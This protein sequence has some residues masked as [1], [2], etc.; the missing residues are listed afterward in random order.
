MAGVPAVAAPDPAVLTEVPC[1]LCGSSRAE[2]RF[3]DPPYRV[4]RCSD[5]T[6]IYVT[7]RREEAK[8]RAMYEVDYWRSPSAKE[9]GYTD[10]LRDEPLYRRTYRRRFAA[11]RRHHPKPGRVLD[12][13]CAAGFFLSIAKEEGW[14]CTGVEVSPAMAAFARERYGLDVRLG[15][16][17]EQ[18][19]SPA[20]FDLV[21]FWDVIEHLPDPAAALREAR[22][23]L[24]PGGLVLVE[25][26][27]VGSAFARLLG[28]RW[29]HYK[30]AEHLYH[31]DP[32]TVRQLLELTGFEVIDLRS[33][34]GG[35]YV[36]FEF[37]IERAGRVHPIASRLLS[38]LRAIGRQAIYVNLFD[39]M[40]VVG[41]VKGS[42]V[43]TGSPP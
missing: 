1:G 14:S 23:L 42:G 39:E 12:V 15:S 7:P 3:A 2:L 31:F 18:G 37:I 35:K 10:Y 29:Q 36:S 27:N 34:L 28:R 8:L 32:A 43:I 13:G 41:R 26:Q 21:T 24:A 9:F 20:T 38:P 22:R 4:V 30:H 25:T 40:V 33:A 11:I 17:L 5:C 16:L 19:F 6:L